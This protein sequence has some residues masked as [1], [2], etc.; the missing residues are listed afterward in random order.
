MTEQVSYYKQ[1][2]EGAGAR[3]FPTISVTALLQVNEGWRKFE[4]GYSKVMDKLELKNKKSERMAGDCLEYEEL[5]R[6]EARQMNDF[7][8]TVTS[9][10][11]ISQI[12]A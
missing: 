1:P 6:Q 5:D 12:R 9:S 8:G 3:C 10:T 4:S 7:D 11:S 2:G